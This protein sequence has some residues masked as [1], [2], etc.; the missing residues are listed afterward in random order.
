MSRKVKIE[1]KE[2]KEKKEGEGKNRA[3]EIA[4]P[5][6][7]AELEATISIKKPRPGK[8]WRTAPPFL[9]TTT[10]D[11]TTASGDYNQRKSTTASVL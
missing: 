6:G 11:T 4:I 8:R 3:F 10:L 9:T 7:G 2:K 5:R 1:K